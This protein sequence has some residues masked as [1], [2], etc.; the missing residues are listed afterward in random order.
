MDKRDDYPEPPDGPRAADFCRG[1]GEEA[2]EMVDR[3][4]PACLC[5]HCQGPKDE[6]RARLCYGCE[7]D[8]RDRAEERAERVKQATDT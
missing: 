5:P 6:P 3:V 2:D 8:E 7:M 1:C 4:C